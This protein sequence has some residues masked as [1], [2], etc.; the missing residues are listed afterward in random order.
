MANLFIP[1]WQ[2]ICNWKVVEVLALLTRSYMTAEGVADQFANTPSINFALTQQ[3][4]S[5]NINA[6]EPHQALIFSSL[7]WALQPV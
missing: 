6:I 5:L 2:N 1:T 7:D 4:M 3:I